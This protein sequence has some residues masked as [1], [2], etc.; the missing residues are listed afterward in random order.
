MAN[1]VLPR[2]PG[3]LDILIA[4][5]ENICIIMIFVHYMFLSSCNVS[6]SLCECQEAQLFQELHKIHSTF[7]A[8]WFCRF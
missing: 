3:V 4:L 1:M 5:V 7:V 8:V 2:H 6:F